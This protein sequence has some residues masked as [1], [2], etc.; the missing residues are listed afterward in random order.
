MVA[1]QAVKNIFKNFLQYN[2]NKNIHSIAIKKNLVYGKN[3][4][5]IWW[6]C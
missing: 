5:Y 6:I 3:I 2:E 4:T 1:K